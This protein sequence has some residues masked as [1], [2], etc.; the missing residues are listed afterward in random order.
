VEIKS[1][2][3]K[4]QKTGRRDAILLILKADGVLVRDS[5]KRGKGIPLSS[6]AI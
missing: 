4:K 2:R 6:R 3:V 5:I 1:K